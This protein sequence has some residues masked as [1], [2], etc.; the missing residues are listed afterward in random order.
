LLISYSDTDGSTVNARDKDVS[1]CSVSNIENE[2]LGPRCV[3]FFSA[4]GDEAADA[5]P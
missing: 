1:F 5:D 3:V 4:L 2:N